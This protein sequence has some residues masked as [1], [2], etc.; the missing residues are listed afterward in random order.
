[1]IQ[2][3]FK[4]SGKTRTEHDLLGYKEVPEEALFGIQTLR[5]IE[6]FQ[7]SCHRLGDFVEFTKAFGIVKKGAALANHGLGLMSD[8]VKDAICQACDELM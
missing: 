3:S 8:E 7:I 4:T 1:M 2:Y 6:N 5:A